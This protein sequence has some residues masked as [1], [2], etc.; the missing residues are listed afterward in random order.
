MRTFL[1]M[2]LSS[3]CVVD[4]NWSLILIKTVGDEL[5]KS[6]WTHGIKI[7][8]LLSQNDVIIA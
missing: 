3:F 1:T 5:G 2:I 7:T 4:V 6:P 8:S